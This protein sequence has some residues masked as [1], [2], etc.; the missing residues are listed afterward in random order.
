[1]CLNIPLYFFLSLFFAFVKILK[2]TKVEAG[3][4]D[5][6][7]KWVCSGCSVSDIRLGGGMRLYIQPLR[8]AAAGTQFL[9][10][11]GRCKV[12]EAYQDGIGVICICISLPFDSWRCQ[13]PG[14]RRPQTP[15]KL[16][17]MVTTLHPWSTILTHLDSH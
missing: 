6:I 2:S 8:Q 17:G 14:V 12:E 7:V 10:V 5:R 1:L 9:S 13:T 3:S 4:N 16:Q 11:W 15:Y